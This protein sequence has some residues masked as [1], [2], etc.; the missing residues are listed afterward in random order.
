MKIAF[1]VPDNR[2]EFWNYGAPEPIIGPAPEALLQGFARLGA[3][4]CEVHVVSCV[5][6][7]V[8]SPEKIAPNIFYHSLVVRKWGWL[9]SFYVPCVLAIRKKL[10]EIAPDVAHGQG[11]ERYAAVAAVYSGLPNVLT[12]H[13]NM[14]MIST[15]N[16]AK[17][18][19]YQWTI[20]KLE[21]FTLPKTDGV[22]CISSYTRELVKD[23]VPKTWILPN[24]VDSSFFGVKRA[25]TEIPEILCVANIEPRKNQLVFIQALDELAKRIPFRVIFLGKLNTATTF[26]QDFQKLLDRRP[27]CHYAGYADRAGLRKALATAHMLVLPS[28]E[29]NCPMVVLESMAA[30]VPVIASRV[31]GVPELVE[32]R[33]TALFCDPLAPETITRTVRELLENPELARRL[34][35]QGNASA[36]KRFEGSVIARRHLEIYR[37]VMQ[38]NSA[39]SAR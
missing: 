37:E 22:V 13:G 31:G 34:S 12:I 23:T 36:L 25:P 1:L 27:W 16:K 30:G 14:R 29:D 11:T 18:L 10:R 33:V 3:S 17:P 32:D 4:E 15:V 8:R 2:D 35:E 20:A 19:S 38:K 26:G 5:K 39:R 28:L 9:K 7:P 6:K 24:A 21:G